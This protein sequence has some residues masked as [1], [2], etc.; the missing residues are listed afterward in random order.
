M[1]TVSR[2]GV[3][4]QWQIGAGEISVCLSPV[5]AWHVMGNPHMELSSRFFSCN[6]RVQG[7]TLQHETSTPRVVVALYLLW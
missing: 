2:L 5:L 3:A 4:K 7:R 1:L 6:R